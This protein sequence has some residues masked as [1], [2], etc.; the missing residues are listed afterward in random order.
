LT[1]SGL[2]VS[3]NI[4]GGS[5]S[6]EGFVSAWGGVGFGSV[7]SGSGV[8][9]TFGGDVLIQG[10]K[11]LGLGAVKIEPPVAD[12]IVLVEDGSVGA[13][14]TV[15]GESSLAIS[16]TDVE[17]LALGFGVGVVS[18][19][20]LSVASKSRFRYLGENWVIF[21]GN[22]GNCLFQ[23][24][25]VIVR[26]YVIGSSSLVNILGFFAVGVESGCR[27]KLLLSSLPGS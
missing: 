7:G 10:V 1:V 24:S 21:P 12:E 20:N 3:N 16:G 18:S 26:G 4:L 8:G 25:Q 15:L 27:V 9:F 23:H 6:S 14:E 22:P 17:H 2:S 13:E 5:V 11:A 19:I